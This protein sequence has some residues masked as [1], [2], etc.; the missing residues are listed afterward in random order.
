MPAEQRTI[1]PDKTTNGKST[2]GPQPFDGFD[3]TN[4]G[5]D[6]AQPNPRSTAPAMDVEPTDEA[7]PNEAQYRPGFPQPAV[8]GTKP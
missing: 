4:T 3:P 5:E 1:V 7:E 8:I 6:T 2:V